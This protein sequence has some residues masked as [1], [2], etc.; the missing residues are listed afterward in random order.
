MITKIKFNK[1]K[2]LSLGLVIVLTFSNVGGSVKDVYANKGEMQAAIDS[3]DTLE[4]LELVIN[5]KKYDDSINQKLKRTFNLIDDNYDYFAELSNYGQEKDEYQKEIIDILNNSVDT[6]EIVPDGKGYKG[7][8]LVE[9]KKIEVT[10]DVSEQT[11]S[12]EIRHMKGDFTKLN[13]GNYYFGLNL[14]FNEGR[15][16]FH[17]RFLNQNLEHN[18]LDYGID[19]DNNIRIPNHHLVPHYTLYLNQYASLYCMLGYNN[20]EKIENASDSSAFSILKES[21][22]NIYSSEAFSDIMASTMMINYYSKMIS[23][24]YSDIKIPS[25]VSKT[26]ESLLQNRI[27]QSDLENKLNDSNLDILELEKIKKQIIELNIIRDILLSLEDKVQTYELDK[28]AKNM[29][30]LNQ[31]IAKSLIMQQQTVSHYLTDSLNSVSNNEELYQF[32]DIYHLYR[33]MVL[34]DIKD[35]DNVYLSELRLLIDDLEKN[36]INKIKEYGNIA[37]LVASEGLKEVLPYIMIACDVPDLN[38]VRYTQID[39]SNGFQTDELL[40]VVYS[41]TSGYSNIVKM[42][43]EIKGHIM[44]KEEIR[45]FTYEQI[46]IRSKNKSI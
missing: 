14:L 10:K 43:N 25:L 3:L 34:I 5:Q 18:F 33:K 8:A 17:E 46:K 2:I 29:E 19:N 38:R 36:L 22:D 45:K 41:D 44:S 40:V 28:D 27:E 39:E 35:N 13:F 4:Y 32:L 11:I 7:Q 1:K 23:Y 15:S 37:E 9:Q 31:L 21:F 20:M 12:H 26:K 24:S 42:D 30:E 6:F 16:L